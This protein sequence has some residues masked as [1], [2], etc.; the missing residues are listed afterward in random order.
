MES[1]VSFHRYLNKFVH[2]SA[3]EFD[4][5]IRPRVIVRNFEKKDFI[6]QDGVVENYFNFILKGVAR[7]YYKSG[8]NEISTQIAQ[9]GHIVLVEDSF[10]GRRPS[11]FCVECLER[12]ATASISHTDLEAIY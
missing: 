9:E 8:I 11:D 5:V 2:L 3:D 4:E 1:I 7:K 12:T 6:S 10:L